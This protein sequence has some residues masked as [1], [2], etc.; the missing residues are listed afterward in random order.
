MGRR[1]R[2]QA[3]EPDKAEVGDVLRIYYGR[4]LVE[5]PNLPRERYACGELALP[6]PYPE[7]SIFALGL[8]RIRFNGRTIDV[9][10]CQACLEGPQK[11]G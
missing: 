9:P 1:E 4:G 10:L 11:R 5:D 6:W 2:Q 3:S 7:R 8:A